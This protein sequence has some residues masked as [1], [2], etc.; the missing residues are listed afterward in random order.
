MLPTWTQRATS[1]TGPVNTITHTPRG[2]SPR[3]SEAP[4]LLLRNRGCSSPPRR[5]RGTAFCTPALPALCHL[6]VLS[7]SRASCTHVRPLLNSPHSRWGWYLHLLLCRLPLQDSFQKDQG[8]TL[9]LLLK[10]EFPEPGFELG[11]LWLHTHNASPAPQGL[12][13]VGQGPAHIF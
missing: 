3:T 7:P 1:I 12:I 9:S 6:G 4:F 13:H 5:P 10:L 2:G 8:E 11:P